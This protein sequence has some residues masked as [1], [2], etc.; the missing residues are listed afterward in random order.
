M[1]IKVDVPCQAAHVTTRPKKGTLRFKR[2][3]ES[4]E[5]VFSQVEL[6]G[7]EVTT[8]VVFALNDLFLALRSLLPEFQVLVVPAAEE[9]HVLT[10]PAPEEGKP[11]LG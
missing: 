11:L 7:L 10:E 1:E 5:L 6:P 3:T 2:D 8:P 4:P 9:S